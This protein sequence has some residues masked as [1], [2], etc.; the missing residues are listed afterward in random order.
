[1]A[2]HPDVPV[3]QQGWGMSDEHMR[4]LSMRMLRYDIGK[5]SLE[6]GVDF[7]KLHTSALKD[8]P[9]R[10][11]SLSRLADAFQGTLK[12]E[13]PMVQQDFNAIQEFTVDQLAT[14][15]DDWE[16]QAEE[17]LVMAMKTL[18][19]SE[20]YQHPESGAVAND[21]DLNKLN[22]IYRKIDDE[23]ESKRKAYAEIEQ[24][25]QKAEIEK[26]AAQGRS[27]PNEHSSDGEALADIIRGKSTPAS[28]SR[29]SN[30]F[31]SITTK[32]QAQRAAEPSKKLPCTTS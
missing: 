23:R 26:R 14:Y 6:H 12:W 13:S 21:F 17:D 3:A 5:P 8:A 15:V 30:F 7:D 24:A 25:K 16:T 32:T 18:F 20:L 22:G 28:D 10:C 29:P 31:T 9:L 2:I 27:Q 1:M 4:S 19:E 11:G